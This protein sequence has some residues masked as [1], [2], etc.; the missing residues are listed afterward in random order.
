MDLITFHE[1]RSW[2][3]PTS[4]GGID[5]D[6]PL[7]LGVE[8]DSRYHTQDVREVWFRGCHSD[9]GG[10]DVEQHTAAIP[11]RWLLQE[12]KAFGLEV[13]ADAESALDQAD[14]TGPLE[15]HEPLACGWLFTEYIPRLELDN[16]QRPP[17]RLF[18]SMAP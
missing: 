7:R 16:S 5:G 3:L 15:I 2:F 9:V 14:P 13:R 11:L 8:P 4:W 18:K 17:R 12:A 10:G 1:Q 6:D